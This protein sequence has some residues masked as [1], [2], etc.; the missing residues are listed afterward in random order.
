[1]RVDENVSV[2][3]GTRQQIAE[4]LAKLERQRRRLATK[5]S[6]EEEPDKKP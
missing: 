4:Q 6:K 2:I 1:M 3:V 5:T